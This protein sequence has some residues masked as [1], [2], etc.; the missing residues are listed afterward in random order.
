MLSVAVVRSAIT[1]TLDVTKEGYMMKYLTT[2]IC[3][4]FLSGCAVGIPMQELE[5]EALRSGDWSQVEKRERLIAKRKRSGQTKCP[6][7]SVAI[8]ESRAGG[9]SC[10]CTSRSMMQNVLT[11]R[12]W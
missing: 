4:A 7:D 12:R 3:I 9:L 1:L 11:G 5:A 2:L 8:C 10:H 6:R